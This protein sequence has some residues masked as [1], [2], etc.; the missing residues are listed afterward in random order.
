MTASA[1]PS[2]SLHHLGRRLML[3]V[4]AVLVLLGGSW[5]TMAQDDDDES[6]EPSFIIIVHKDNPTT[7]IKRKRLAQIFLKKVK[8]WEDW[9]DGPSA[10][11]IDW[12]DDAPIRAEFTER[13]HK[14]RLSAINAYWQRM[15]FSGRDAPP[16]D[17]FNSDLAVVTFVA[18]N[19][20]AV[21]YVSADANLGGS[22]K[23]LVVSD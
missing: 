3:L 22:V 12:I 15:I 10:L 11:P 9:D 16:E 4:L 1:S 5:P 7:T 2:F 18:A 6:D 23:K 17:D 20:G 13:I 21:G 14:K 8:S 19:P